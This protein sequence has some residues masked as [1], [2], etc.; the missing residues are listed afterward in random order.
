MA[1]SRGRRD[2]ERQEGPTGQARVMEWNDNAEYI[3]Q[4]CRNMGVDPDEMNWGIH[5]PSVCRRMGIEP[6]E[7][8]RDINRQA[9]G[10]ETSAK[11]T[12][13]ETGKKKGTKLGQVRTSTSR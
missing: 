10:K 13:V 1:P 12:Q 5:Q 7:S 6:R 4:V 8:G 11:R 2:D 9:E 3:R